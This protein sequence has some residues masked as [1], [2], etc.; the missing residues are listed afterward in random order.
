MF[1]EA[2]NSFAHHGIVVEN[3]RID[4]DAMMKQKSSAV[5]GLTKGIEGLFK[6]NKVNNLNLLEPLCIAVKV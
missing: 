3:P 4:I 5:A 2:K 6:K 1:A